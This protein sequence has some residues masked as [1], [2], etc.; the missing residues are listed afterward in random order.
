MP[1]RRRN[2]LDL[3][4][5]SAIVAL[6][7]AFAGYALLGPKPFDLDSSTT[8]ATMTQDAQD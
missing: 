6:L 2:N 3:L 1:D 7:T 5:I 4:F 8:S